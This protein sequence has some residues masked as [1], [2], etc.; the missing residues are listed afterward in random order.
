MYLQRRNLEQ[1]TSKVNS[2]FLY[3]RGELP[4]L[5]FSPCIFTFITVSMYNSYI[6]RNKH[7]YQKII[8]KTTVYSKQL[9]VAL[10][11]QTHKQTSQNRPNSEVSLENNG[12]LPKG[13]HSPLVR[14]QPVSCF[15]TVLECVMPDHV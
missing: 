2:F 1:N 12:M 8:P 11:R 6:R 9:T 4:G 10:E 15:I 3:E 14:G 7:F 13:S 5:S